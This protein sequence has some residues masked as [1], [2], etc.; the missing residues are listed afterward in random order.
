M[1]FDMI[2][3]K[4]PDDERSRNFEEFALFV[5]FFLIACSRDQEAKNIWRLTALVA[6]NNN[7]I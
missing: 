7:N 3:R 2:K 5:S 6:S 1:V 4:P